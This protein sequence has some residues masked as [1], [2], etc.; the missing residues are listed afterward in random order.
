[1]ASRLFFYID[2]EIDHFLETLKGKSTLNLVFTV[3]FKSLG[4]SVA[5]SSE[6]LSD[7]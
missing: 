6:I 7:L 3:D 1:M 5:L 2:T 4:S